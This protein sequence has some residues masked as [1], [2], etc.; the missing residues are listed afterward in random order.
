MEVAG[1][2]LRLQ[3]LV[4]E[5]EEAAEEEYPLEGGMWTDV[6]VEQVGAVEGVVACGLEEVAMGW[7]EGVVT[8]GQLIDRVVEEVPLAYRAVVGASYPLVEH[9]QTVD[10]DDP[11]AKEDSAQPKDAQLRIHA[12]HL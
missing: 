11:L 12:A 10:E 6:V 2:L 1:Y 5:V 7:E 4:G 8:Q 3:I 9:R